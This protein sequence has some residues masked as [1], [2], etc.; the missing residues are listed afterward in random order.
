[1]WP[2]TATSPFEDEVFSTPHLIQ[3]EQRSLEYFVLEAKD[4][5]FIPVHRTEL[6]HIT[7]VFISLH[8]NVTLLSDYLPL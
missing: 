3:G 7:S 6:R 8:H 1:M 4:P 2:M 5:V